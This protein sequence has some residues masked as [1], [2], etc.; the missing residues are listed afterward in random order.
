M[1][2]TDMIIASA[3]VL[4]YTMDSRKE[5]VPFSGLLHMQKRNIA[6]ILEKLNM[7]KGNVSKASPSCYPFSHSHWF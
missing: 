4:D 6:E 1:H 5:R 2:G 7:K 3:W